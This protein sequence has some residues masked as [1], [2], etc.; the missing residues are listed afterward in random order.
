M[1]L[2]SLFNLPSAPNKFLTD[3]S[4]GAQNTPNSGGN[5]ANSGGDAFASYMAQ[6]LSSGQ[7]ANWQNLTSALASQNS[8][9]TQSVGFGPQPNGFSTSPT[10]NGTQHSHNNNN[11]LNKNVKYQMHNVNH[12]QK[13]EN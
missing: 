3:N 6:Q 10:H 7:F 11:K 9:A 12:Y 5:S 13:L 8:L 4:N 2:S 1:S